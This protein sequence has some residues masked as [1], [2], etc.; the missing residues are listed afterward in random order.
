M[1]LTLFSRGFLHLSRDAALNSPFHQTFADL[2]RKLLIS[3][4]SW[5]EQPAAS[6]SD[7]CSQTVAAILCAAARKRTQSGLSPPVHHVVVPQAM[8]AKTW[9]QQWSGVSSFATFKLLSPLPP[10]QSA[11]ETYYCLIHPNPTAKFSALGTLLLREFPMNYKVG[12][13]K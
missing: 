7:S 12:A 8:G 13:F 4:H 10:P 11:M 2:N 5:A 1:V 6:P 3:K 9:L